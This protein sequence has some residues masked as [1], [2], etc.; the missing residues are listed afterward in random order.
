MVTQ[1]SVGGW[2]LLTALSGVLKANWIRVYWMCMISKLPIDLRNH[3][4]LLDL[5]NPSIQLLNF[6]TPSLP[7]PPS[8]PFPPSLPT[9]PTLPLPNHIRLVQYFCMY[10]WN[11]DV[12]GTWAKH[13][14]SPTT[15]ESFSIIVCVSDRQLGQILY[16][17]SIEGFVHNICL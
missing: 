10:T 7:L 11:R 17:N 9:T 12:S 5:R 14:T 16:F 4:F 15:N 2:F 1:V 8:L 13:R 3:Q 6:N